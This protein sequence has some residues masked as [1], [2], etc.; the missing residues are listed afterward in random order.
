M[1]EFIPDGKMSLLFWLI[2]SIITSV[3]YLLLFRQFTITHHW[4]ILL[5]VLLLGAISV[6][7]NYRIFSRGQ[8]G[9]SYGIMTGAI[10]VLVA[11]GGLLFFQEQLT[12]T[13]LLGLGLI[14]LGVVLLATSL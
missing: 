5:L 8:I 11:L 4:A 12:P 1:R 2:V 9:M 13:S 6:Y 7:A 3:S 10:V 14:V